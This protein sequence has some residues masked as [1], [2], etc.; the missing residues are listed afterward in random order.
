[1]V[2]IIVSV[3]IIVTERVI[4]LEKICNIFYHCEH[5]EYCHKRGHFSEKL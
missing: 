1:M 4:F 2:V 5:C 3:L